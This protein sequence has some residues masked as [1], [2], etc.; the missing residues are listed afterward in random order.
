MNASEQAFA[1]WATAEKWKVQRP[2]WPDFLCQTPEGSYCA[3]EVKTPDLSRL[4]GYQRNMAR[5]LSAIGLPCYIWDEAQ[6][7]RSWDDHKYASMSL[8]CEHCEQPF[9]RQPKGRVPKWCSGRCK[10]AAWR[11]RR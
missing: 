11:A 3:V 7:L 1:Q 10:V 8:L 2:G 9:P 6:G 5:V 4:V